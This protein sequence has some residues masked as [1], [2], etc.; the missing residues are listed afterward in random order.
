LHTKHEEDNI[1]T[2]N[3]C[4]W[5]KPKANEIM[6]GLVPIVEN[7]KYVHEPQQ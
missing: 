6:L 4:K 1:N 2:V 7:E 3:K 5:N